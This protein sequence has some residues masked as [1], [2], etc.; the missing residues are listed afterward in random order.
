MRQL[1]RIVVLEVEGERDLCASVSR[2]AHDFDLRANYIR[3]SSTIIQ[4]IPRSCIET[5]IR[6]TLFHFS[7]SLESFHPS[8]SSRNF[9]NYRI[10]SLVPKNALKLF[11]STLKFLF[12]SFFYTRRVRSYRRSFDNA[13][14]CTRYVLYTY[15]SES[16][17]LIFDKAN[18]NETKG[19]GKKRETCVKLYIKS[20][21]RVIQ[22]FD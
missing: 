5:M 3:S 9:S 15:A 11:R 20:Q 8:N 2:F 18:E 6:S 13:L 19:K 10:Y 14:P 7:L 4:S 1:V 22:R 17:G 16:R 21:S 12:S